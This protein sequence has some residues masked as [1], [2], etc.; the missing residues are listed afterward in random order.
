MNCDNLQVVLSRC[1]SHDSA[2]FVPNDV[3]CLPKFISEPPEGKMRHG[4]R[5]EA[6]AAS[7]TLL[8]QLLRFFVQ[9]AA[10]QPPPEL[11]HAVQ[12]DLGIVPELSSEVGQAKP[13]QSQQ[14]VGLGSSM[15]H[16]AHIVGHLQDPNVA[17][18]DPLYGRGS[19]LPG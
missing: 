16:R 11:V 14:A 5:A 18:Q 10:M 9:G 12:R 2:S 8:V 1:F 3:L 15:L 19:P 6:P 13:E 7:Q 17:V 4:S